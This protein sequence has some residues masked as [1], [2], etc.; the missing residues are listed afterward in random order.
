VALVV[1]TGASGYIGGRLVAYLLGAGYDVRTAGR[2]P[3]PWLVALGGEHVVADLTTVLPESLLDGADALV[4]LAGPNEIE[5]AADPDGSVAAAVAM[6]E[7]AAA[8]VAAS[9]AA[10]LVFLSTVHVY[11]PAIVE[12]AVLDE[13]TPAEPT[14]PYALARR[15]SEAAAQ[16]VLGADR[17]VVLRLTNAV[18]APV[19]ADVARWTL[20]VNDL[21]REAATVGTLTLRSAGD[22]W[23]DFVPLSDVV[24]IIATATDRDALKAGTYNVGAGS[25]VTVRAM[26]V[27]VQEAFTRLT[28]TTPTLIAPDPSGPPPRPYRVDVSNLAAQGLRADG[29]IVGAV[30]ET[31]AFCIEHRSEL[32]G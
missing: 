18:G 28:G 7:R 32:N 17:L 6:T 10:Q 5:A 13:T 1:V 23:R 22:Q 8:A 27:L 11:G 9:H 2:T 12:D 19:A 3:P 4:H 30:D 20:L 15:R 14:H 21:C 26:A 29:D 24:R 16:A 31:A 25:A